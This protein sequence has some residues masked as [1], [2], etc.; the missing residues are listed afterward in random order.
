MKEGGSEHE[1]RARRKEVIVDSLQGCS[2]LLFAAAIILGAVIWQASW[3]A[4]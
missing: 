1:R 4:E 2:I 3:Y